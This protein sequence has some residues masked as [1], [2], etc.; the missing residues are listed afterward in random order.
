MDSV[1]QFDGMTIK[2]HGED[3]WKIIKKLIIGEFNELKIPDWFIK[4][5]KNIINN[6]H[7]INVIKTYA[8]FHDCGKPYC[9]KIDEKGKRHFPNHVEESVKIF[10]NYFPDKNLEKKLISLDMVFHTMKYDDIINLNLSKKDLYTLF[11]SALAEI[12]SNC[13]MFGGFDSESFKIKFKKLCKIGKKL[14]NNNDEIKYSYVIIRN[15]LTDIQKL[16]QSSHVCYEAG[17]DYEHNSLVSV[18]VRDL[19]KLKNTMNKLLELG[20]NF[21]IFRDN[22]FND[23]ITAICTEPIIY[24]EYLKKFKLLEV[25]L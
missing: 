23:E 14:F 1:N 6:I 8:L 24:N 7:D 4:N 15:D 22:I 13:K 3:V 12:N 19:N 20:I 25:N 18:V 21:K 2:Q 17:M 10:E 16:I 9:I 5:H 11:I